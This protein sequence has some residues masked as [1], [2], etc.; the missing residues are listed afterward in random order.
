MNPPKL[1]QHWAITE[2]GGGRQARGDHRSASLDNQIQGFKACPTVLTEKCGEMRTHP[3][4][5]QQEHGGPNTAGECVGTCGGER[6]QNLGLVPGCQ[7]GKSTR[8]PGR[9]LGMHKKN[10]SIPALYT[11]KS[12]Q[13]TTRVTEQQVVVP[14]QQNNRRT[15]TTR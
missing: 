1:V 4:R 5:P 7:V 8:S 15:A 11:S 14:P 6:G 13:T 3:Q 9:S 2:Q 12:G 10:T